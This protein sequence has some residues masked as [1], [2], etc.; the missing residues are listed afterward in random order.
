M[1][2]ER[3][4]M[5]L[6]DSIFRL[7]GKYQVNGIDGTPYIMNAEQLCT[8]LWKIVRNQI[9]IGLLL[10]QNYGGFAIQRDFQM[11]M[12]NKLKSVF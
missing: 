7:L 12:L 4:I 5:S 10:F 8:E 1:K 6:F 2:E 3:F 9:P 11:N